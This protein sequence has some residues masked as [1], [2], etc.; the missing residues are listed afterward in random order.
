MR[1]LYIIVLLIY[2]LTVSCEGD[3]AREPILVED[4]FSSDL[5][6]SEYVEGTSHNKALEIVNLTGETI[7]LAAEG[8][9]IRKQSNGEG[10]WM[11]E[12]LLQ[13][14]LRYNDV[15]V[16][17]NE[18]STDP[19]IINIAQ[20]LKA[21]APLD[22]N[23]ND[24]VGLFKEGVLI[25]VIGE[26]DNQEDFGKDVSLRRLPEV[27]EPSTIYAPEEWEALEVDNVQDLGSY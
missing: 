17:A 1:P 26:V 4:A 15:F 13:G 18:A 22:F 27:T 9:S 16:I 6:F 23:G 25:D 20:Q 12:V 10:N 19:S 5:F 24:P 2:S 11:G 8:Y 21:G 3:D 7:D 14:Q